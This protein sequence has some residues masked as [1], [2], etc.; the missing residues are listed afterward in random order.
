MW[1]QERIWQ[2]LDEW[3]KRHDVGIAIMQ[4]LE[5]IEGCESHFYGSSM[6]GLSEQYSDVDIYA[7][8]TNL[9]NLEKCLRRI[10]S[11][12]TNLK[13]PHARVSLT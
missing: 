3:R 2:W 1:V 7:S 9:E 11:D 6:L 8:N 12:A 5:C 10:D 13:K 4:K